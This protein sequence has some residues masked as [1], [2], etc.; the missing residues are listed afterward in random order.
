LNSSITIFSFFPGCR[1]TAADRE[2]AHYTQRIFTINKNILEIRK[3]IK[4]LY[5]QAA[6]APTSQPDAAAIRHKLKSL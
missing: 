2:A 3:K 4:T 6:S 5:E 1:G